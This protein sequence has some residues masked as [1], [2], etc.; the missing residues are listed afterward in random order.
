MPDKKP[1]VLIMSTTM[2]TDRILLYSTFPQA[3]LAHANAEVWISSYPRNVEIWEQKGF[4]VK[5]FPTVTRF[6]ERKNLLRR[7]NDSAWAYALKAPSILSMKRLQQKLN[8]QLPDQNWV[9]N[10]GRNTAFAVGKLMGNMGLQTVYEKWL[11][12]QLPKGQES[13]EAG[14]MLQSAMPDLVVITNPMWALES[15]IALEAKRLQI[16][17][18][19]LIPSWD[20]I[21]TKSRFAY[22]SEAYAVWSDIRKSELIEYYPYTK[23]L[24]IYS[25]GAPQYDVFFKPEYQLTREQ[26]CSSIGLRPNL[27]IVLYPLGS[28][29]FIKS[30]FTTVVE[31]LNHMKALG[32]LEHYQV[33]IRPHPHKQ[34]RELMDELAQFHPHVKVQ[35]VGGAGLPVEKRSQNEAQI[36][37]WVNTILHTNV[38]INM[39]SSVILDGAMFDKP[40]VTIN[41]DNS[42]SREWHS[43]VQEH[44]ANWVHLKTI[45]EVGATVYCN[46]ANELLQAVDKALA[47]PDIRHRQMMA[48][49]KIIVNNETGN[50]GQKLALAI[51]DTLKNL[52]PQTGLYTSSKH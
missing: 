14:A 11:L 27:P 49:R 51:L 17:I 45:A 4:S 5:A 37:D 44:I 7:A 43:F 39:S 50:S 13:P 34:N 52:K 42:P 29:H 40:T 30:E 9:V 2:L 23:H 31:V 21:T 28:P 1:K 8:K 38:I 41:F 6:K 33:L 32:K 26:F 16:P 47:N 24:P 48:L 46:D 25:V 35:D 10:F 20:N 18:F 15:A 12:K 19:S 22:I 36:Q 3:L